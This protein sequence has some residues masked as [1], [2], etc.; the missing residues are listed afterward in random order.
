MLRQITV[1]S[2]MTTRLISFTPGMS[3]HEAIRKMLE[4]KITSALV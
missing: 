4:H 1:R 3:V 2:Y